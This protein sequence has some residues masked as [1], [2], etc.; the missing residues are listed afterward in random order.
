MVAN[1]FYNSIHASSSTNT[2]FVFSG[3]PLPLNRDNIYTVEKMVSV[4]EPFYIHINQQF[5]SLT[6]ASLLVKVFYQ[7][8]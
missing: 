4:I 2:V 1:K 5:T 3:V 8:I 7:L 6:I